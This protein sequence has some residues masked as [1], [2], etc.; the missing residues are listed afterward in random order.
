MANVLFDMDIG[1]PYVFPYLG[2]GAGALWAHQNDTAVQP[3]LGA[4]SVDS[5]AGA[6]FAYQAIAGAAFPIPGCPAC[7]R[8]P[9]SAMSG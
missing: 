7:R 3:S 8:P 2:A 4:A 9:S 5:T 6:S 1:S